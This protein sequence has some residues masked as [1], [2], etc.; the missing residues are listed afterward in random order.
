MVTGSGVGTG[1]LTACGAR[2]ES[3]KDAP[4]LVSEVRAV[5]PEALVAPG[6]TCGPQAASK[7]A[8]LPALVSAKARRVPVALLLGLL[9]GPPRGV[10]TRGVVTRGVVSMGILLS[11]RFQ[12]LAAAFQRA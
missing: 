6:R 12:S 4:G 5:L 11:D 9:M 10:A 8:A 3:R 2:I 7:A 1:V